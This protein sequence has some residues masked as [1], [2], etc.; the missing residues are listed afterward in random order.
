MFYILL[1][2][3]DTKIINKDA[4]AKNTAGITHARSGRETHMRISENLGTIFKEG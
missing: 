3:N 1:L 4:K 2:L